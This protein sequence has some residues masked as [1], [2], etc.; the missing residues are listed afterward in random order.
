M[1][2]ETEKPKIEIFD[3]PYCTQHGGPVPVIN[4]KPNNGVDVHGI[5]GKWCLVCIVKALEKLGVQKCIE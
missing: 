4:T 1:S 5:A 3:P 2:S